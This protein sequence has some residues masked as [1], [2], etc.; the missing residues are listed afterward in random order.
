MT[1]VISNRARFATRT[2]SISYVAF[3]SLKKPE[4][5]D[6]AKWYLEGTSGLYYDGQDLKSNQNGFKLYT[7]NDDKYWEWDQSSWKNEDIP[8]TDTIQRNIVDNTKV[9]TYTVDAIVTATD[10]G[11]FA[12]VNPNSIF[13]VLYDTKSI[14]SKTLTLQ[15]ISYN[16][17]GKDYV[18]TLGSDFSLSTRNYKSTSGV[19]F[20]FTKPLY[21]GMPNDTSV[22]LSNVN[23]ESG[24]QFASP[25]SAISIF[26]SRNSQSRCQQILIIF[27]VYFH[28][29]LF[30]L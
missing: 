25:L 22:Q 20:D 18:H 27:A 5:D 14:K 2:G 23:T 17:L 13:S 29:L 16:Y 26:Y 6:V 1:N 21:A 15:S 9:F 30:W 7:I 24:V 3:P 19:V 8:E 11:K 28:N 12:S 4:I 10:S